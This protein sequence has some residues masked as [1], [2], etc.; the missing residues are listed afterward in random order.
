MIIAQAK[1]EGVP[2]ISEDPW[3]QV[4]EVERVG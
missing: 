3:F 1:V 4:Y 2:V